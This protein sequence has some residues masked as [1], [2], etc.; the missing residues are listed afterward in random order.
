MLNSIS[1]LPFVIS[2]IKDINEGCIVVEKNKEYCIYDTD[3]QRFITERWYSNIDTFQNGFSLCDRR[4]IL[5]RD[6]RIV[7]LG[8]MRFDRS[9]EII[10][11]TSHLHD[12]LWNISIFR[13][14]K[15]LCEI[16]HDKGER[17]IFYHRII[18]DRYLEVGSHNMKYFTNTP[19]ALYN[20]DG[21]SLPISM[22]NDLPKSNKRETVKIQNCTQTNKHNNSNKKNV[23]VEDVE[24]YENLQFP[25]SK[26]LSSWDD[27]E[28][29]ELQP[30]LL[31]LKTMSVD[32]EFGCDWSLIG[33]IYNGIKLWADINI[34]N[35]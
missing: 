9:G 30:N 35:D 17:G 1:K 12:G 27:Y 11:S 18:E 4:Y 15:F 33:Y 31:R 13:R 10:Y 16:T 6:G 23:V 2:S 3:T 24:A 26:Y 29:I 20:F 28:L 32:A 19:Q 7:D 14:E 25:K 5:Y 34:S 22:L 8:E 21:E